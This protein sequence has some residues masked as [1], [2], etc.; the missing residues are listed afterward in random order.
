MLRKSKYP[1]LEFDDDRESVIQPIKPKT[2]SDVSQYCLLCY[3]QE[4]IDIYKEE[5]NL[6]QISAINSVMC[7][8]PIYKYNYENKD[9]IIVQAGLG[10]P[11]S[12]GIMEEMIAFGCRKFIASGTCGVLI[13]D[14]KPGEVIIPTSAVREEGVSYHY[15][16]PSREIQAQE[17]IN[18]I[19]IDELKKSDLPFRTGKVW[20]TDAFYRET[21]EKVAQR[22]AEG[23]IV[24]E[25]ETSALYAVAQ[26]R[27]VELG[28]VLIGAD[29][30]SGTVWDQRKGL[31]P[32]E[33]RKS[34][35]DYCI[36]ILCKF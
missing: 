14:I 36:K 26:F 2:E 17:K 30:V 12:A 11:L 16:P 34:V 35:I 1:I 21:R 19:I 9:I 4:V 33:F 18:N 7:K 6:Q 5:Y 13:N 24:V 23:C 29:D 3:L 22:K 20:T 8:I 28:Y 27:G 15:L 25:M 32:I 31:T 10:A